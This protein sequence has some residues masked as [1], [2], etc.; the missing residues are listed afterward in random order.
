MNRTLSFVLENFILAFLLF[1]IFGI[2]I[3]ECGER[4]GRKDHFEYVC[5]N[6]CGTNEYA[7]KMNN[8]KPET[9]VCLCGAEKN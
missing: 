8:N 3:E 6:K 9:W 1:C 5:K 7:V 4:V 2:V